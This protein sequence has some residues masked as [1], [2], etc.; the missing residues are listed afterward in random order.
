MRPHA[1]PGM[2]ALEMAMDDLAYGNRE[3]RRGADD[4]K[5]NAR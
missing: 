2:F 5:G 1:G 3:R 4:R